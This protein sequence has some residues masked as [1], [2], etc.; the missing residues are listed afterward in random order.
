MSVPSALAAGIVGCAILVFAAS[1]V[2]VQTFNRLTIIGED[3]SV[4]ALPMQASSGNATP[5]ING[6]MSATFRSLELMPVAGP[7]R[8]VARTHPADAAATGSPTAGTA[9]KSPFAN[10]TPSAAAIPG[11]VHAP[12]AGAEPPAA[13]D[14]DRPAIAGPGRTM[15]TSLLPRG[16]GTGSSTAGGAM[17]DARLSGAF[18]ALK[19]RSAPPISP[20]VAPPSSAAPQADLTGKDAADMT[21]DELNEREH[22]R[23]KGPATGEAAAQ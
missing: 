7:S 18:G 2:I 8:P 1:G 13:L 22:Q 16:A 15:P 20:A 14:I 23:H 4:P 21:A 19:N 17:M 3:A 6:D 11:A 5:R 12:P 9:T 10:K